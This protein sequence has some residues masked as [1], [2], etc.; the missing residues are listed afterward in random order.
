MIC[1]TIWKEMKWADGKI[2]IQKPDFMRLFLFLQY[3]YLYISLSICS[4]NTQQRI[5][6]DFGTA[7]KLWR[8][9]K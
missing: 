1:F 2:D 3:L 7:P 8:P 6:R 9:K 5:H 4:L